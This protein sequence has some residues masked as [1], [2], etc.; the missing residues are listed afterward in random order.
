MSTF[1][2]KLCSYYLVGIGRKFL[3]FLL[4]SGSTWLLAERMGREEENGRD[5]INTTAHRGHGS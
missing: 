1:T 3:K 2:D 4:I 5:E